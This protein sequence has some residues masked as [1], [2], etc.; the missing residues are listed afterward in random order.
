MIGNAFSPQIWWNAMDRAVEFAT[1]M[2][3]DLIQDFNFKYWLQKGSIEHND[4][5]IYK[6]ANLEDTLTGK[7]EYLQK[8]EYYYRVFF[9]NSNGKSIY[10]NSISDLEGKKLQQENIQIEYEFRIDALNHYISMHL[11]NWLTYEEY[12]DWFRWR[13]YYYF[14]VNKLD[15]KLSGIFN[16]YWCTVL[17]QLNLQTN[18]FN[19]VEH[20]KKFRDEYEEIN[21][22]SAT[23]F[24]AYQKEMKLNNS[25]HQE[26]LTIPKS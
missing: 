7:Y 1:H 20:Y 22:N 11:N 25:N 24:L 8:N 5:E 26:P 9:K 13:M 12:D 16:Y 6:I 3:K 10:A 19:S 18:L 15:E 4:L 2:G 17:G 21:K 14:V 23:F